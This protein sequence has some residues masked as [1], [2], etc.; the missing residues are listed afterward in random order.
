MMLRYRWKD[1]R[2]LSVHGKCPGTG[3]D[4]RGLSDDVIVIPGPRTADL[5]RLEIARSEVGHSNSYERY[6]G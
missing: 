3:I 2:V 4:T 5:D 6:R 1:R